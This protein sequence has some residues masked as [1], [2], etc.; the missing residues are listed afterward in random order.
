MVLMAIHY[1]LYYTRAVAWLYYE[2]LGL[3]VG[4]VKTD[5]VL[6]LLMFFALLA[7]T[8][9]QLIHDLVNPPA[10]PYRLVLLFRQ[11]RIKLGLTENLTEIDDQQDLA[12][13]PMEVN[14]LPPLETRTLYKI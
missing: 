3:I 9:I 14:H 12:N 8:V 7:G 5:S 13:E 11:V 2:V 1:L 6:L 4:A 10:P